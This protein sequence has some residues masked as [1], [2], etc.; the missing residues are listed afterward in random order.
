MSEDNEAS[1]N[2]RESLN[3]KLPEPAVSSAQ[4]WADDVL[5]RKQLGERLTNLIRTQSSPFTISIHGNWGTGKT[6]LLKRWQKDLEKE[7]FKAIYFNAWDDDFCNDPLLA[8]LGQLA[9]YFKE[10]TLK[11][12]TNAVI[13]VAIPLLRQ[14]LLGVLNKATGLTLD[15]EQVNQR[16]L[17]DEYLEQRATR[18]ELR[19]HLSRLSEAVV[20]ETKH[21]MVF[22]IDELDR[23]RP[24]FAI[25]L[26]ERVK[27]IFD[28]Q[29]TVFVFGINRE[30][31]CA[32]LESE[33][34][35]IDSDTYLR[36]F[37]DIEFNLPEVE[38][39]VYC[40]HV[41]AKVELNE[42]FSSL[43]AEANTKLHLE[44]CRALYEGLPRISAHLGLSLRDVDYCV[45]SV[46]MLGKSL[47]L[48][49][50]IHPA[51]LCVLIPV[52]LKNPELY[53]RFI[54]RKC[55]ASEVID[56]VGAALGQMG[57]DG[58]DMWW[59]DYMEAYLYLAES[60]RYLSAR[61]TPTAIE[62]LKLLA[63]D[64][65]LNSPNYLSERLRSGD[66]ARV[67]NV[68]G[69]IQAEQRRLRPFSADSISYLAELIDLHQGL[70]RR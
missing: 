21:P 65:E 63:S 60:H 32:S 10:P 13:D 28:V 57:I 35:H 22:I 43:S 56:Y 6:F 30:Q 17:I 39:E 37:F 31:L 41:M 64:S 23:C 45:G 26:L 62:Q 59:L 1:R 14:N 51:I 33:Y 36:R 49:R 15:I 27:H 11:S 12:L 47:E 46:A 44:D 18:D 5:D 52:K 29:N 61:E 68:L 42:Y 20:N 58:E 19:N 34:G 38:T 9:D 2:T 24:T 8:M 48:R 7:A 69:L 53:R 54:Q 55:L 50:H 70:V 25:E 3:L 66:Q 16:T 40:R 67:S 4:P